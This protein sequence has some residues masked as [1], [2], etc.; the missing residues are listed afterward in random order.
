MSK[1]NIC[2]KNIEETFLKKIRGTYVK[3]NKKS[4]TVCSDC[5]KKFPGDKLREKLK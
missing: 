2:N 5:Q 3:V 1:C 4:K